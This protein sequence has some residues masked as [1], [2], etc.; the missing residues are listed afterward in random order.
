[1]L[2][3]QGWTSGVWIDGEPSTHPDATNRLAVVAHHVHDDL[4]AARAAGRV[5]A[6]VETT[7]NAETLAPLWGDTPPGLLLHI[8]F[9]GCADTDAEYDRVA[10]EACASLD[11][12][13]R[14]HLS[15]DEITRYAGG[16]FFVGDQGDF[17]QRR[18]HDLDR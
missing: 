9:T 14:E 7:I 1:M 17:Q 12:R 11:R 10:A 15:A 3:D 18:L 6:R 13:G 5:P 8:R 4:L 16:L 2:I